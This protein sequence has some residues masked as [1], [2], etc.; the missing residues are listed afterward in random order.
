MNI[1]KSPYIINFL[2]LIPFTWINPATMHQ[3]VAVF[4]ET[5]QKKPVPLKFPYGDA[6]KTI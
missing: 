1:Y 3:Q 6:D 4:Q 5:S 2:I